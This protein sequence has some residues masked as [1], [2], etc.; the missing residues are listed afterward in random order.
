MLNGILPIYKERGMTSHDVVFK[1]RKILNMKKI[2]HAGTLDPEVDGVLLILLG[3][4]TRVS[5]YAMDLGKSYLAEVCLGIKTTT[6]DLT[7]KI[8]QTPPIYSAVKV[9]GKK[10]YEYARSGNFNVEIPS[11]VVEIYS[12]KLDEESIILKNNKVYFKILV[13]C[14]KGTYIRT[15][16]TQIGEQLNVPST[17]ASLTRVRSGE[18]TK[19]NC[20]KISDIEND[21]NIVYENILNKEYALKD[22]EFIEVPFFRAKQIMCGLRFRKN[23]FDNVDFSTPKVFTY[24]GIALAV[25]YLKNSYDELLTVKT[26]FPTQLNEGD[27]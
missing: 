9:G 12:I 10:L 2:G 22:Y 5:D 11:R 16:A 15:L 21:K 8:T 19:E 6:E 13:D 20:I 1:L 24:K 17:M 7:G 27:S 18:I 14:G 3:N 4:A 26:V 23:Q 25:Y